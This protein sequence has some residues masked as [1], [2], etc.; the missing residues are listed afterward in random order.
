MKKFPPLFIFLLVLLSSIAPQK[1]FAQTTI[2]FENPPSIG[3]VKSVS[4]GGFTFAATI[5]NSSYNIGFSQFNGSTALVDGNLAEN[6]LTQWKITKDGGGEFQ[7]RSI[8]IQRRGLGS[9]SGNISGFKNGAPSGPAKPIVFNGVKDFASDPDFFDVDEIRIEATDIYVAIDNFTYGPVFVP[10]DT[11]PSEVTSIFLTGTPLS[12]VPSVSFTVNF[13]KTAFNVNVDDFILTKTGSANGSIASVTDSGT[14]YSVTVNSITGEG[15]IR[16]DLKSGTNITNANGNT[17]T[18]AFTSGQS[19]FVSPC[20]IETF[21]N[22]TVGSKSF[23]TGTN[24]FSIT[25]NLEVYTQTPT[26]GIG[27]SRFV[28]KNTG[29]GTYTI[30]SSSGTVLLNTIAFY[31]SSFVDGNTPTGTGSLTLVGKRAGSTVYTIT[32][33]SGFNVTPS[34]NSGYTIL[35][36]ATEGGVDNAT[37]PIDQLE[38]SIG[39]AFVYL[40][41]DNFQF[42]NDTEAP[43]GYT[44]TIDQ[45]LIDNG[46]QNAVSFTFAGAEIGATYNYTF[47]S[48]GGGTDVTGTGTVASATEQITGINL[49]GLKAGTVTLSFTLSDVSGNT[50]DTSTDTSTRTLNPFLGDDRRID[51]REN[52]LPISFSSG[53]DISVLTNG[54]N[55]A[56]A[57]VT[58]LD[59]IA[60]DILAVGDATPFAASTVGDVITL[61]GSGTAAQISAALNSITYVHD[62]DDPGR[63]DSDNSRSVEIFVEDE[64]GRLSPTMKINIVI[65]S[66]NDDP[67]FVSLPSDLTVTENT[68]S[69]LDLSAATFSDVDAGTLPIALTLQVDLGTLQATSGG[70]VIV[71]G[72][73][74][75]S[76]TLTGSQSAIDSYLNTSSNI[77]YTGPE[78]LLGDD[79]ALLTV[80]ANDGGN[81]GEGGGIPVALG[82]VS[83]TINSSNSAPTDILLDNSS[84]EENQSIGT[85]IGTLSATDPDTGD[86]FTFT[87]VPGTGADDNG[88][89]SISGNE[90]RTAEVFD[91]DVKNSYS[92]R[93]RVTDFAGLAFEKEF[94]I[95][96]EEFNELPTDLLLDNNTVAE[97]EAVGTAVGTFSGVDPN[98][99]ETFTYSFATGAGDE[100]NGSFSLVGDELQTGAVFDFETKNTYSVRVRVTDAGGLFLELLFSISITDVNEFPVVS[101]LIPNQSATEDE[102]YSFQFALNTFQDEDGDV[103][104]YSAQLSGGG[105][106]PAWLSFNSTNR[107]F[108]GTPLNSHVGTVSIDVTAN[109]G[110]GGTVTDTFNIVV[111]NANDAPTVA[112][113]ISDQNATEDQ[114]YN[115]QFAD[116]TFSDIDVGDALTYT[117]QLA[118]G[119][120]LPLW[121]SFDP[122]TR[123]FSGTPSNENV[124]TVSIDV[125][126]NDGNGGT[127]TDTFDIV[128]ANVN[129]APTVAIAISNQNATEDAAF[130]F[131]FAANTFNDIDVGDVLTY[132][133]QLAGGGALPVWLSFDAATRTF[134]GTPLNANVGTVSIDVIA[135]DGN[136]GTV[137]DTFDIVVANVNDAPTVANTISD[138]N[139]T[140]D[141]LFNFQFAANTFNDIDIGDELAYSAQL[142]GGAALPAWLDFE[143]V[144]RTFSGTPGNNDTGAIEIEVTAT[145]NSAAGTSTTFELTIAGVNNAPEVFA[146]LFIAV[147]E[148]E[149]EALTGISFTDPDAGN[150]PVTATFSV[151]SGTLAATSG[152]VVVSGTPTSLILEG[153]V[154]DI[155]AF[156]SNGDLTFTT[157]LNATSDVNLNISISDNGNTGIGGGALTDQTDVTIDVTAVNDAPEN[158]VPG[159]QQT[160]QDV[161]LVLSNANGNLISISDVDA[162]GGT[163]QVSLTGTNGLISLSGTAGLTFSIGSGVNDGTMTFD[164]T[165]TNIN[166]ALSGMI[167]RPTPGFNGLAS[168]SITSN[169]LGFSGSGGTQ[170]DTDVLSIAVNSINPII[171]VVSSGST[172]GAYKIGDELFIQISFDQAVVVDD[173]GG[174]PTLTLETGSSDRQATYQSG[175]GTTTLNF[176]YIVQL[177]DV[178]SDLGYTGTNALALNGSTIENALGDAAIL[179]LPPSGSA[180]SLSGQKDLVIDGVIPVI[181]S[182]SVPSNGVYA[183]GQ[184]LNFTVNFSEAVTVAGS[185]QFSLTVGASTQQASYLSGSGTSAL[186]FRYTVQSG[187][188]DLNGIVAGTLSLNG[189]TIRDAAGNN[190]NLMLN[191]IGSTSQVLVDGVRP[192][193]VSLSLDNTALNIGQSATLSVVFSERVSGLEVDDF[194]VANGALSSLT[195]SDGGVTWTAVLTP[196]SGVQDNTNSIILSISGVIDLAGNSGIGTAESDNYSIDTQLPVATIVVADTELTVGETS[197]VTVSFTEEVSGLS[198]DDFTVENGSLSELNSSDGGI[199]WTAILTPDTGVEDDTNLITLD[200][201]G[202]EDSAENT[203]TGTSNSNNYLVDTAVPAGYSVTILPTLINGINETNFS[204]NLI[205]GEIGSEYTYTISSDGGGTPI[206]GTGT[207]SSSNQIIDGIDVSGLPDGELTLTLK[208]TDPS[209]NPGEEASDSIDKILPAVLTISVLTQA[210]ENNIDAEFEIVS[211]NLFAAN[212]TVTIQVSGTATSGSDYIALG[213]SFVFPA[214]TASVILPV[215]VIDDALVEGNETVIVTL[216][217]SD[218]SL[219]SFG[220]PMEATMTII[221]NDIPNQLTVTPVAN[222]GKEYGAAEP[223][224]LLYSVSGFN[225]GDDESIITGQLSRVAGE[226]VAVYAIEQGTL[227]AGPNYFITVAPVNFTISPASLTITADVNQ[228]KIYGDSDPSLTYSSSGYKNGDN[229]SILSGKLVRVAGENVG[230][231]GINQGNLSAGSNYTIA[232]S[233]AGFEITPRTLNV[234]VDSNQSKVFGAADP[235]LTYS[236]NN[237]GNGDDESIFTGALSRQAGENVGA[238]AINIEDLSAGGNYAINFTGADFEITPATITGVTFEDESFVYDGTAKSLAISGTL[239]AGTS[240]SYAD[241][242][243]TDV[244]SQEVTA[245]ISGSNYTTLVLTA[246]LTITPATITGVTF[247]DESFVY[248]GTA[249]SLAISGTLPAGTSVSYA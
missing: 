10:V 200:N 167:F 125:I 134:S 57:V 17:G 168:L 209:G 85:L 229:Q 129:N 242:S 77:Q 156:I 72:S 92:I 114:L 231:Y 52:D 108:S 97:N 131:Q 123:T 61:S 144:T 189:A 171:T 239:P 7:F 196:T 154:S 103:L 183:L 135:N 41:V 56:E 163:V 223:A 55:I 32:K 174:S 133:A 73:G 126:A 83:I 204:F 53:G 145:D 84:V 211:D 49:S 179:S 249:K 241:N 94:L 184:N 43:S 219:V 128:V 127:V 203:G 169:D 60:G 233:G 35:D 111:A 190:A 11:D 201:T 224:T 66:V 28:L 148:D 105:A 80:S 48:S 182:V 16:L 45:N 160:D 34:A 68:A 176:S 153:S 191:G 23:S 227:D 166:T 89:F 164:G 139:A 106:L 178:S 194:T 51:Y 188:L 39:G 37:K 186:V 120:A 216:T 236:A 199:T 121:L 161:D 75:T 187:D 54:V 47:S 30:N 119:G 237:F 157:A 24:N 122:L 149:V 64:L 87:L 104:S 107:T 117:G 235:T 21:E 67:T 6:G 130:N 9:E 4:V 210:D 112:N 96:V 232:Y 13:S 221:D 243:R 70:G 220:Q 90:L 82:T 81:S 192:T 246:D 225:P 115:F 93:V 143:P 202:F 240:V 25:G 138:Q 214:N 110:N 230:S 215:S 109:D 147:F 1:V 162:G 165:I 212:T 59:P 152:T 8:Y 58:F 100:D 132:S 38:I 177:G 140:E 245:T 198:L 15:S 44:A 155:N 222:Q 20:L 207:V 217:G 244:G 151:A 146:P 2:D 175:S 3:A 26:V 118:G 170:T 197:L 79:A 27:G 78:D 228:N 195:S 213:T 136:G 65:T 238:Y 19:H 247:E 22:E 40:N 234:I 137:T 76:I 208:L 226:E 218:N 206:S 173:A 205:D 98:N 248:D 71:G 74:T 124:D 181:A 185:P 180:N 172:N 50:G 193:V 142:S 31:L 5:A 101:N 46:N 150:S 36:F 141:Q 42:C 33:T 158:T 14:T 116:N 18:P 86:T 62:G 91:F 12:N 99:G 102:A 63:A 69:N 88:S 159:I 113:A 95:S 29:T